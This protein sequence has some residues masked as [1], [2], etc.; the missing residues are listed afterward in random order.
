MGVAV[1]NRT[2]GE[3]SGG[4]GPGGWTVPLPLLIDRGG[5]H[6]HNL[7]PPTLAITKLGLVRVSSTNNKWVGF[8]DTGTSTGKM[9]KTVDREASFL[10]DKG[11]SVNSDPNH[12]NPSPNPT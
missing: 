1:T 6:F 10:G 3:S 4:R 9:D 2:K 8:F 12:T 5:T 11:W 7:T